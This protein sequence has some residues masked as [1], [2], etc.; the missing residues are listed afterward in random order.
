[1]RV[2]PSCGEENPERARFCM[3]CTA[4]L[5]VELDADSRR[6][7]TIV[8]SDLKGSTTLGEALD[9][10]T[11]RDVVSSYFDAMRGALERHGGTV[12]KFIGDAVMAVFGLPRAHE[13]DAMR[14]VRAT[15]DMQGALHGL[16]TKLYDRWNV[17]LENR[18]GVYTGEVVAGD[19]A[20]G[21]RLVTGDAVNTAARLEQ[22]AA[23]GEILIGDT[24]FRLVRDRVQAQIVAPLDLKGKTRRLR[25]Y[26]LIDADVPASNTGRTYVDLV[27]RND[28]LRVLEDTL[29]RVVTSGAPELVVLIGDAG[30]GKSRLLQEFRDRTSDRARSVMGRCPSYGEGITLLPFA[31]VVR[32]A[33]QIHEHDDADVI[34]HKLERTLGGHPERLTVSARLEAI[35]GVRR[36]SLTLDE[37]FWAM[38]KL[39]DHLASDRPLVV[40]FDDVHWAEDP[41]FGFTDQLKTAVRERVLIVCATRKDLFVDRPNWPRSGVLVSLEPLSTDDVDDFIAIEFGDVSED[42]KRRIHAAT[43]GNP[44]FIEQTVAMLF[45]EGS[46]VREDGRLAAIRDVSDLAIPPTISA[47]LAARIDRLPD[48]ERSILERASIVGQ[49]FSRAGVHELCAPELRHGA[50]A[51][52]SSLVLRGFVENDGSDPHGVT[53]RFGH[54][55]IQ[56][57][58][59]EGI[60]KKHRAE[61]HERFSSWLESSQPAHAENEELIGYHLERAWRYR[62]ELGLR[63]ERTHSLGRRAGRCLGTAGERA[64]DRGD[65][66]AASNLLSRAIAVNPDDGPALRWTI[67]L[68]A[69]LREAGHLDEAIETLER[70]MA[71]A[72]ATGEVRMAYRAEIERFEVDQKLDP[73]GWTDSAAA[74]ADRMIPELEGLHD[75]RGLAKAWRMVSWVLGWRGDLRGWDEASLRSIE[76]ARL[77]GDR[78]EEIEVVAGLSI[79]A[80]YGRTPADEGVRRCVEIL[81]Q[82]EGNRRAEAFVTGCLALAQALVGDI[83]VARVSSRRCWDGMR[84]I[85]AI[86]H[87]SSLIGEEAL[88]ERLAGDPLAAERVI[89]ER[90]GELEA[91]GVGVPLYLNAE[92]GRALCDQGRYGEA[93]SLV[94]LGYDPSQASAPVDHHGQSLRGRV[95]AHTGRIDEALADTSEAVESLRNTDE[96]VVLGEVLIDHADV[97]A[98][99]GRRDE[100]LAAAEEAIGV[101]SEKRSPVGVAM[102]ER[103]MA[104]YATFDR[105]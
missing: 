12:E 62:M 39:M 24:T 52:L 29:D 65:I 90:T 5:G 103:A 105:R 30:V 98:L 20:T 79:A 71:S 102:V 15:R 92:L 60:L 7:V 70:A 63:D 51:L 35:L 64:L 54:V 13:D 26:R 67:D 53:L 88:I 8:F 94:E 73:P 19:P 81:R 61:L 104:S 44:L 31:E 37:L 96:V 56:E 55:L 40:I 28:E 3:G 50:D 17:T 59:Y 95:W 46:V 4:R 99:A 27:G 42:L 84:D 76:Y 38:R 87:L 33:M 80:A 16:N 75:Y 91:F 72:R 34:R 77:A 6:V 74:A 57:A 21:Q 85:G 36:E 1:M 43:G 78:R 83:D 11:L 45:E 100:S 14:A 25:A 97:L 58:T 49:V 2:C 23:P 18:T 82:V 89:R 48:E 66:G 47:L 86:V 9:P 93:L 101:W 41:F 10:E 32:E 68:G 22:A 69:A